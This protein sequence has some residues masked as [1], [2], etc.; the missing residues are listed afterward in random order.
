MDAD[1]D[2]DGR[3]NLYEY[4]LDGDPTD[5]EDIGV[6]PVLVK[7][8]NGFEYVHLRRHDDPDLIYTV[9]TS[10]NLI[11]GVWTSGGLSVLGTNSYNADYDEIIH[12]VS[13]T[14]PHSY[15]RLKITKP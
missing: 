13:P 5:D 4:A 8:G 2:H 1:D 9:E 3:N 14:N 6:D 11:S 7:T 15:F 10:T 12:G